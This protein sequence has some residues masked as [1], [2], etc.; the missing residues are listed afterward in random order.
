[1]EPNLPIWSLNAVRGS[2]LVPVGVLDLDVAQPQR[3]TGLARPPVAC[4]T[5]NGR[6]ES[7]YDHIHDQGVP[8]ALSYLALQDRLRDGDC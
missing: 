7:G 2:L 1:M 6:P 5:G 3:R 4:W 8:S